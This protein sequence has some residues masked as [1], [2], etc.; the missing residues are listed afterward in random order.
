M[1]DHFVLI[2]VAF[3]LR[4]SSLGAVNVSYDIAFMRDFDG[5]NVE[6]AYVNVAIIV[7]C[8]FMPEDKSVKFTISS[9]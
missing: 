5:V 6:V 4:A 8:C 2:A 9:Q 3:S 1:I 7:L